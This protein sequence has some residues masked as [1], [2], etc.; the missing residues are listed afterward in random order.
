[1]QHFSKV[2]AYVVTAKTCDRCGL[3]AD[4]DTLELQ[5]FLSIERIGGFGSKFGDGQ[6]IRLDLCQ[7]CVKTVLGEWIRVGKKE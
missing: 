3:E 5:E 7:H 4:S 6:L 1:M 2:E